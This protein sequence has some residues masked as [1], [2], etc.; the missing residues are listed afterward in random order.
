MPYFVHFGYLLA[1]KRSTDRF[2]HRF[3]ASAKILGEETVAGNMNGA[4]SEAAA[5]VTAAADAH[6]TSTP[7]N[8]TSGVQR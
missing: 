2:I 8:S 1:C 7:E 5:A 4:S 3:M 6:D